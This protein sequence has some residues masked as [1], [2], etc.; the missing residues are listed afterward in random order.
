MNEFI[1]VRYIQCSKCKDKPSPPN[2]PGFYYI[3]K[4]VEGR[5]VT[6]VCECECH[7]EWISLN[8]IYL[9]AYHNNI[10]I[11][12]ASL[13][14]NTK[15]YHG[16]LS[17][18]T[19]TKINK[20]I[21]NY[22]S[23]DIRKTSLYIYGKPGTQKTHIAQYI[24][25]S[26]FRKGYKAYY[27]QMKIFSNFVTN[28]FSSDE[29]FLADR[30][31]FMTRVNLADTLIIDDAF[32]KNISPVYSTGTQSPYIEGFLHE[33]VEKENKNIIYVTRV[34]PSEIRKNGYSESLEYFI[35]KTTVQQGTAL[36]LLDVFHDFKIHDIFKD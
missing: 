30:Q 10:W 22:H 15:D 11:D 21:D 28:P 6:G 1:P 3:T 5:E 33:R 24:G 16:S 2:Q 25:L 14:Y 19:L 23:N 29:K 36:E 27:T 8:K 17:Q 26:L 7:R 32:D 13:R 35:T 4:Q 34:A 9:E 18:S 31:E 12:H 20:Y